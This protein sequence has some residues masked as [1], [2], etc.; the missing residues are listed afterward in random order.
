MVPMRAPWAWPL[1]EPRVGCPSPRPSPHSFV[2]GRGSYAFGETK[3]DLLPRPVRNPPS[4]RRYGAAGERGEGHLRKID[5]HD[6]EIVLETGLAGER[7]GV[8]EQPV[9]I[10]GSI[11]Q[12][13]REQFDKFL[14]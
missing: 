7:P 4:R 8:I 11:G 13:P 3:R 5:A 12:R 6:R 9:Q 1:H 2:M 14:E 10:C